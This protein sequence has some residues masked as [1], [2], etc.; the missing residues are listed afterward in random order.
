MAMHYLDRGEL[1]TTRPKIQVGARK[2]APTEAK[3]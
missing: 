2:A 3:R 1:P